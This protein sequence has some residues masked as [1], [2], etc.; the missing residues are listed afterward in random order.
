[1]A[2]QANPKLIGHNEDNL[3]QSTTLS[4]VVIMVFAPGITR[5]P[6]STS[7]KSA[8]FSNTIICPYPLFLIPFKCLFFPGIDISYNQDRDEKHHFYQRIKTDFVVH[9]RPWIEEN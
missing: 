8:V 6:S 5:T 9:K 2:Q 1:M 3:A 7:I 4:R